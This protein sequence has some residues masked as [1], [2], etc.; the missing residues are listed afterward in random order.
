MDIAADPPMKLSGVLTPVDFSD[1][2]KKALQYAIHFARQFGSRLILL[3]V[4]PPASAAGADLVLV[5]G[6][7][8]AQGE[9]ENKAALRLKAWA[10]EFVPKE[11]ATQIQIC[12][13]IEA[14]EIV[15]AAKRTQ[16]GLM[17]I[18]THG[19]T[20]RA[21]ALAGSLAENL[22]QLAP[23]PVLVVRE[24]ERDFIETAAVKEITEGAPNFIG[25]AI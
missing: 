1:G 11:I 16:A 9:L 17:V 12:R 24:H 20:G 23:C 21:H 5:D 10:R 6:K 14:I 13:G 8:L 2:S 22:V 7:P 4:L 25:L 19:R 15:N 18:S 3:H